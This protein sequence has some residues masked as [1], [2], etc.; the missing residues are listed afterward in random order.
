MMFKYV[1]LL[2]AST[3]VALIMLFGI[4]AV[5]NKIGAC[6]VGSMAFVALLMLAFD[7]IQRPKIN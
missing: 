5:P 2:Y 3:A 1:I 6:V 4:L 7:G